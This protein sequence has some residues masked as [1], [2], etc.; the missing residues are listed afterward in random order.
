MKNLLASTLVLLIAGL[1][2]ACSVESAL[3]EEVSETQEALGETYFYFRS[4][5]TG[6]GADSA[7]RLLPFAGAGV[8]A[9]VFDVTQPWLVSGND[10]ASLL[11]TDQLD[12][13]G[14]GQTYYTTADAGPVV[15]PSSETLA[16]G[17]AN[18]GVDYSTLGQHRVIVNTN[19][20]PPTVQIDSK[21]SACAG[22]CPGGLTCSLMANGIPTCAP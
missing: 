8:V 18:F 3:D 12:G 22:V 14:T 13:W 9:R 11:S 6:W 1:H 19:A 17:S 16:I 10:S 7:T 5:A 20:S 15:V 4:N 2:T 21:A